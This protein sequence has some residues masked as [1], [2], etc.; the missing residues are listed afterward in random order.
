MDYEMYSKMFVEL[1]SQAIHCPFH[2]DALDVSKGEGGLLLYLCKHS[3]ASAGE[4]KNEFEVGSGRI[5]NALKSLESK[6][7]IVRVSSPDDKRIVLVNITEKGKALVER[8]YKLFL[9]KMNMLLY[10]VGEKDTQEFLRIL[11]RMIEL[12]NKKQEND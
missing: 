9:K 10:E 11:K 8:R 7:M 2:Q 6:G 12:S 1:F 5:A 4:L 3:G